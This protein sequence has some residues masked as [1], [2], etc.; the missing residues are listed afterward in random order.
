MSPEDRKLIISEIINAA[1]EGKNFCPIKTTERAILNRIIR[2][3][4]SLYADQIRNPDA[5]EEA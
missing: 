4:K 1:Q 3:A 2:L 5:E